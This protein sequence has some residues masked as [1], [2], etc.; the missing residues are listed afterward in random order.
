MPAPGRAG[1][2]PGLGT[3]R[4]SDCTC[5]GRVE[6]LSTSVRAD[7]WETGGEPGK[8]QSQGAAVMDL[9]A[10]GERA[11]RCALR[12]GVGGHLFLV[13]SRVFGCTAVMKRKRLLHFKESWWKERRAN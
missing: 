13:A 3:P 7:G 8:T 4:C 2:V 1:K 12:V 6:L 11:G 5:A 9:K 10:A